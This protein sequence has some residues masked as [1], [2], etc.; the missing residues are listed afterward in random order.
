MTSAT[1]CCPACPPAAASHCAARS[2]AR[3]TSWR[4]ERRH[5]AATTTSTS[6]F[7]NDRPR[8]SAWCRRAAPAASTTSPLPPGSNVTVN[9]LTNDPEGDTVT[10]YWRLPD[11]TTPPSKLGSKLVSFPLPGGDRP[12][13]RIGSFQVQ[14]VASDGKG[15]YTT[16]AVTI[17]TDGIRFSGTVRGTDRAAV[18]GAV[19]EL[20][21]QTTTTGV[22]GRFEL[23]V[24]EAPRY[25]LN[26]SKPGYMPVSSI[27]YAGVTGGVWTLTRA[28]VATADPTKQIDVVNERRQS[29]CISAPSGAG[30]TCGPGVRVV[31]PP[32]AL[33]NAGGGLPK[34]PVTLTLA[35]AD[36]AARDQ[37]P[38]DATALQSGEEVGLASLA[39]AFVEIRDADGTLLNLRKEATATV[40][41]PVSRE[42]TGSTAKLPDKVPVLT[43]PFAVGAVQSRQPVNPRGVWSGEG[44]NATLTGN[45]YVA[46]V[47]HFSFINVAVTLAKP[48][49][50][51]LDAVAMPQRFDLEVTTHDPITNAP[52]VRTAAFDNGN[53]RFHL[54]TGLPPNDANVQL[55]AF[56]QGSSTPIKLALPNPTNVQPPPQG[57]VLQASS[58]GPAELFPF[59]PY[60]PCKGF[61]GLKAQPQ[62]EAILVQADVPSTVAD[63][64]LYLG[65]PAENLTAH[66]GV[67]ASWDTQGRQYYQAVDPLHLRQNVTDFR[68]RNHFGTGETSAAYANSADL[69]FGREMHCQRHK[70]AGVSG[71]DVACYVTN[72][73]NKDSDDFDD[74]VQ[75]LTALNNGP[76]GIKSGAIATV[77]MEFSRIEDKHDPT[78][79]TFVSG[80]RVVKFFVWGGSPTAVGNQLITAADLDGLGA[81]PVP[82]LCQ[83]CH[84]GHFLGATHPDG[85]PKWT[86]ANADLH[87]NFIA[88]DLRG[89]T[90][91]VF[92]GVDYKATQQK[93]FKR[94]NKDIVLSTQ[95]GRA[96][97][98]LIERMY[99]GTEV[100]Q[101]ESV[102]VPGWHKTSGSPSPRD[103]YRDV[104]A[105]SCRTCHYSQDTSTGKSPTK[106][107]N[108]WDQVSELAGVAGVTAQYVCQL[109]QMPHALITHRRFWLSD[110]PKEKRLVRLF[111]IAHGVAKPTVKNCR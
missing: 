100:T 34:G 26:I 33:V 39:G 86:A 52:I 102:Q 79:K 11:G 9:A 108:D 82:Q 62:P 69:G 47:P 4:P 54:I 6:R 87:S 75:A 103:F 17:S 28:T 19:V 12:S 96:I 40:T 30:P 93:T 21:G 64:F 14:A 74:F 49:C 71:F 20:A 58:G 42:L 44:V 50:I 35:T 84:G 104:I 41:I 32:N 110:N 68:T 25:A 61:S 16:D 7:P 22:D 81:R 66:P 80:K 27:S 31:I 77:G 8:S 45:A 1:T 23:V 29:D 55:R 101:N 109:Q 76:T 83:V 46:T 51:R 18:P 92:G 67:K 89:L 3:P 48:A 15:G 43:Y 2:S 57:T 65:A 107:F 59:F 24:Q 88:F 38:G 73:G 10:V 70:V 94:L 106:T 63:E 95:P 98:S 56:K 60:T 111:A 85:T 91:P 105:P 97:R 90:T 36:P 37:L 78:G 13:A 53:L 99:P 5:A 72:Y